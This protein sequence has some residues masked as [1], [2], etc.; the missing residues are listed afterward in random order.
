MAR[1]ERCRK[2]S[3]VLNTEMHFLLQ[4][5]V[6]RPQLLKEG[7]S[8]T[9]REGPNI[10]AR[11][12]AMEDHLNQSKKNFVF[13]SKCAKA[14]SFLGFLNLSVLVEVSKKEF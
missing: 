9:L 14:C 8:E 4:A 12:W 1:R 5:K 6:S 3:K 13:K 2:T 10:Q 7:V 11:H